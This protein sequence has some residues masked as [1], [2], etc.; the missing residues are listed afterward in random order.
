M[1]S[2]NT[3]T[4]DNNMHGKRR[5]RSTFGSDFI[6]DADSLHEQDYS[7]QDIEMQMDLE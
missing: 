4:V 3:T 6:I 1:G 7:C 2:H 5:R